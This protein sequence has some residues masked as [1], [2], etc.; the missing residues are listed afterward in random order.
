MITKIQQ[1]A[2][3]ILGGVIAV[4]YVLLQVSRR[5]RDNAR[6]EAQKQA[7]RA[8]S[9]EARAAQRRRADEASQQAKVKGEERVQETIGRARSGDRSHFE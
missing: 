5:Q 1:W 7:Q 3:A 8:D 2:M 6:N 4:M 9:A